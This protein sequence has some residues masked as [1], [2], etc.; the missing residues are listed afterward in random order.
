MKELEK[1]SAYK[2]L[3]FAKSTPI[4]NLQPREELKF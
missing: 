1:F 2:Q 3:K 4:Q